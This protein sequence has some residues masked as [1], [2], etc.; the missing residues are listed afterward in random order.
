MNNCQ[1]LGKLANIRGMNRLFAIVLFVVLAGVL[2]V[3]GQGT[4]DQYVRIYNQIQESDTLN[5]FGQVNQ[6]LAKYVEAQIELQK[7]KRLNPEWNVR[8]VNFRLNYLSSKI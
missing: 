7:F 8:V 6:A 5:G 1:G 2:P 3:H 4:D